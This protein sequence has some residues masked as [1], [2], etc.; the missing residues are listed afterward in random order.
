MRLPQSKSVK[1]FSVPRMRFLEGDKMFE[2]RH[3]NP[4]KYRQQTR[5]STLIV[6]VVF[7]VLAMLLSTLA[8]STFGNVEG[9]NLRWNL[10]GVLLGLIITI[11][12]VRNVFWTQPWMESAVYGWQLKRSLMRITN[13]MHHVEAG[14]RTDSS[15][16]MKLLRFYHLGLGEMHHLDGNSQ[17]LDE[18]GPQI[19]NHRQSMIEMG[20]S[21]DQ[22]QLDPAWMDTLPR[23]GRD[24]A[25]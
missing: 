8:V 21:I 1:V 9:S 11:V 5:R 25:G 16:A 24:S 7:A 6:V 10:A 3:M 4:E 13:T 22:Y 18:L 23:S 19:D 12:L 15:E 2:I 17:A 14:V 20:L